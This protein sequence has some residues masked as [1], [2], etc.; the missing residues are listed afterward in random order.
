MDGE[1]VGDNLVPPMI[2]IIMPVM[3][4]IRRSRSNLWYCGSPNSALD[5]NTLAM[6]TGIVLWWWGFLTLLW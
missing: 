3:R 1:S 6:H 5:E 4:T 2:A